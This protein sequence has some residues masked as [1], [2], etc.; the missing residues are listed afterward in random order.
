MPWPRRKYW[1]QVDP[2]PEFVVA[3]VPGDPLLTTAWSTF[4]V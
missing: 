4:L 1:K 2:S 3:F